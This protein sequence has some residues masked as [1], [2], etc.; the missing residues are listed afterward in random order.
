MR[1]WARQLRK[2]VVRHIADCCGPRRDP[3]LAVDGGEVRLDGRDAD[4]EPLCDL[5]I[6]Q[7]LGDEKQNLKLAWGQPDRAR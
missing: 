1:G 3:Q 7:A 2:E 6:G 4:H 5:G